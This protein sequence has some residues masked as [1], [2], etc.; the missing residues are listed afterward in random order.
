MKNQKIDSPAAAYVVAVSQREADSIAN[1][2]GHTTE[3][4]A[5][6]HLREVKGPPTDPYYAAQYRIYK[7]P[8]AQG[9]LPRARELR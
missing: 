7:C 6:A 4:E 2:I 3:A 9:A 8:L 5:E 1:L